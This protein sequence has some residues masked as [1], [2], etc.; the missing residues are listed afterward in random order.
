MSDTNILAL[1]VFVTGVPAGATF[2][3]NTDA[4]LHIVR[5]L[6]LATHVCYIGLIAYFEAFCKDH[7]ASLV[8]ICPE[9]LV[10]FKQKGHDVGIDATDLLS[11]ASLSQHQIGFLIEAV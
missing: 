6:D 2:N 5:Q 3:D 7:F 8:N 9:L 1:D 10:Q 11:L 4:L